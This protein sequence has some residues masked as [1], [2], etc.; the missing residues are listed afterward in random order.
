MNLPTHDQ[1]LVDEQFIG[2]FDQDYIDDALLDQLIKTLADLNPHVD[3]IADFGGGNGR[4]LD[5]LLHRM[6]AAHG[7]NYE[8]STCL[9]SLNTCS[10]RK[11]VLA[12]SFLSIEAH[13][14]FDLI[15]MN[16]VLHHLVGD[17]LDATLGLIRQAVEIVFRALKPGGVVVISENLLQS[18]FPE[19]FSSAALFGITRSKLLKPVV[20]RMRDGEAVAGVGIYYMSEPQLHSLFHQ[21]EHIA[22]LDRS[23][24]DYGWKL[25]LIGVTHV[26]EKVLIF[27]KPY[28]DSLAASA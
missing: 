21:F 18:V 13:S 3:E 1:Q 15:L 19:R 5:R 6:P 9:Q 16:W 11:T 4:F 10:T 20:L 17:G 7:T 26:T 27:R 14:K 23:R 25:K 12:E 24:H 22:T 28:R 2:H 8:I